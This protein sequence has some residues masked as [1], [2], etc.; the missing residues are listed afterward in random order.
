M[1]LEDHCRQSVEEFGKSWE[2]LHCWL[3]EFAGSERYGMRHRKVRHH[4]A[5][6]REAARL[7]G[8]EAAAVARRHV[9]AD[10]KDEGWCE[11]RNRI[12][13]DEHD[14]VLMGLF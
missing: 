10:L 1:R 5:G 4:E 6:V 2:E 7:F 14:Y 9:V 3:D 11:G 8:P 13:A 12:P